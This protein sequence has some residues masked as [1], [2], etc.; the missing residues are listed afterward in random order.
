MEALKQSYYQFRKLCSSMSAG[1]RATLILVPLLVAGGISFLVRSG[2]GSSYVPLSL[3]KAFTAE[4]MVEASRTL[5]GAGLN[6]FRQD[7]RQILVPGEQVAS[8]NAA[9]VAGGSLPSGW[10]SE[11]ERKFDKQSGTFTSTERYQ[12]IKEIQLAKALREMIVQV[13]DVEDANVIWTPP[14]RHSFRRDSGRTATVCVK[15]RPGRELSMNLVEGIRHS[16]AGAIDDLKSE[17]VVVFDQVKMTAF[18]PEHEDDP[19]SGRVLNQ[20]KEFTSLYQRKISEQLKFIPGVIVT[21]DVELDSIKSS[22][23]TTRTPSPITS[24]ISQRDRTT[25][26]QLNQEPSGTN[27]GVTPNEAA[28]VSNSS[29]SINAQKSYVAQIGT[30]NARVMPTEENEV[31]NSGMPKSVQVSVYIPNDYYRTVAAQQV[32][33][34]GTTE[35]QTDNETKAFQKAVN[36]RVATV[37]EQVKNDVKETVAKS[38][39]KQESADA[40]VVSSYVRGE[41]EAPKADA[42]L[43]QTIGS[44]LSQWGGA[45]G[46]AFFAIFALRMIGKSVLKRAAEEEG[47]DQESVI[48]A[49]SLAEQSVLPEAILLPSRRDELQSAVRDNPEMAAAVLGKWLRSA[50]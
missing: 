27:G 5:S 28:A 33:A 17:N 4:E 11:W 41:S 47:S 14:K 25:M 38:I 30:V 23:K 24:A 12:N 8:Y 49:H 45:I 50:H 48:L 46:L 31:T 40:V 37:E 36:A 29:A 9:L 44:M 26:R 21:V 10:A 13:P 1:Q 42:P 18:A 6:D 39:P 16:V 22:E 43:T 32:R 35:G 20:I 2:A 3:G 19:Y 15:T 34:G 7:G